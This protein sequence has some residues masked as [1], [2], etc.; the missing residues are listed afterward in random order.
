MA[1]PRGTFGE[2]REALAATIARLVRERGFVVDGVAVDG[3]P[4]RDAAAAACIGFAAARSA[5]QNM[6]RA[7]ELV[8]IGSQ[9]QAGSLH[10]EALYVLAQD[11]EPVP[12]A[13]GG[14][15]ALAG[16]VKAWSAD[17]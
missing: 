6:R 11:L 4:I 5:A 14:I 16:V 10:Y 17:D 9:K 8:R 7:G 15:E 3:V 13:W 2:E 1:R 12:Q